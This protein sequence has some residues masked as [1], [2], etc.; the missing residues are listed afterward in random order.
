[1]DEEQRQKPKSVHEIGQILDELSIQELEDRIALLKIE[2]ERLQAATSRKRQAL[3][4]AVSIFGK[5][6]NA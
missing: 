3:D 4:V 1:M 5:Q 6:P 2:I